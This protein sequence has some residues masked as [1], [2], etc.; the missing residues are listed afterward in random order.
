VLT[1]A[2]YD[3]L[4]RL[5]TRMADGVVRALDEAGAPATVVS[6]GSKG[7]VRWDDPDPELRMLI[8]LWLMNRGIYTTAGRGQEWNVSVAHDERTADRYLDAL[9]ALLAELSPRL[10]G[11]AR[12]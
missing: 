4:E 7:A 6:I 2:A 9:G 5:G 11:S 10:S 12:A 8:W 1:A 3:E